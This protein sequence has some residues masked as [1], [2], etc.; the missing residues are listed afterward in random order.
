MPTILTIKQ[1]RFYFYSNEA[2]R[3]HIHVA[4]SSGIEVVVWLSKGA[5]TIKK[6]S[7]SKLV[8]SSALKLVQA[9][10][11]LLIQGWNEYF[12]LEN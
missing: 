8:D 3:P 6:S 9:N 10:Y 4:H 2:S 1:F 11:E 7:G 5:I 12:N